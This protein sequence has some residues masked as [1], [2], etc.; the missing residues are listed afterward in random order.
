MKPSLKPGITYRHRFVVPATKTVPALYPEADEFLVMSSAIGFEISHWSSE[1]EYKCRR[2][3]HTGYIHKAEWQRD[4][5]RPP[6]SCPKCGGKG[7]RE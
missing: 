5:E 6:E 7:Y 4:R 3:G 1:I 2:C